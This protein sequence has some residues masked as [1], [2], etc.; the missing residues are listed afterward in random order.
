[1]SPTPPVEHAGGAHGLSERLH[2]SRLHTAQEC[3]HEEGAELCVVD[4]VVGGSAG[5]VRDL[6]SGENMAVAL[7]ANDA[8]CVEW[9][10]RF[11]RAIQHV[12]D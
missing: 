10:R 6:G 5:D 8:T 1:M 3:A 2:L 12:R 4:G 11:F 9:G 7:P